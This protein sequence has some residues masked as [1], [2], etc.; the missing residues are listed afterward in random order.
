MRLLRGKSTC[1]SCSDFRS[2][3]WQPIEKLQ[4]L[5]M[6]QLLANNSAARAVRAVNLKNILRQI[7]SDR[8]NL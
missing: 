6:S 4:N 3:L 2:Q 7:E 5:R 8:S 1:P